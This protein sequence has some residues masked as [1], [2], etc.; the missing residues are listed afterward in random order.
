MRKATH[1]TSGGVSAARSDHMAA[2]S[3]RPYSRPFSRSFSLAVELALGRAAPDCGAARLVPSETQ[4]RCSFSPAWLQPQQHAGVAQR[5]GLYPLQV[6]KLRHAFVI[7]TQQFS[8][9]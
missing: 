8:V 9:H 6:E 2:S 3:L 4:R 1:T 5:V 7:G